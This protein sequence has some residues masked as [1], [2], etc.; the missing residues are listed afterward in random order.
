MV[1][2]FKTKRKWKIVHWIQFILDFI[3]VKCQRTVFNTILNMFISQ[4]LSN[5]VH[6]RFRFYQQEN[7]RIYFI[8]QTIRIHIYYHLLP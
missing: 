4:G 7:Q 2:L 1:S 8:R 3:R 6:I 5:G